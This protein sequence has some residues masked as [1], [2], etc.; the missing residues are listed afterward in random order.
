MYCIAKDR[1]T[2]RAIPGTA[3]AVADYSLVLDSIYDET[4]EICMSGAAN[5]P[6]AGDFIYLENGYQGIVEEAEGGQ[7]KINLKCRPMSALFERELYYSKPSGNT[8][9]EQLKNMIDV[10]YTS[11]S[12]EMYRLPY[13]EVR[14]LTATAGDT[15]PD[16]DD[17]DVY[18]ISAY[19]A[20]LARL[21]NIFVNY[22]FG[23]D[24]L[25]IEIARKAPP[26]RKIDFSDPGLTVTE[27]AFSCEQTGKITS[28]AEDTGRIQEWYLLTDGSITNAANTPGRVGGE[29]RLLSVREEQDVA[30]AVAD[31][32]RSGSYS[33]KI[34]FTAAPERA[35]FSFY[36]RVEI[37][38]DG[39]LFSS[40]IAAVRIK[41]NSRLTEYECGELRTTY[42][43][44]KQI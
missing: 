21:H 14:A 37:S 42:P 24:K 13:L 23:R 40:Y 43:F 15:R 10:N 30:D 25:T 28:R 35:R 29:W 16:I 17:K 12:D 34:V 36:D 5:A 4:S 27:Q 11:Q 44:K 33:H 22:V 20:K 38:L 7:G 9:E 31:E 18:T 2:F 41:K 39:K 6:Q 26:L 1:N 32:F 3:R 8:L 19:M